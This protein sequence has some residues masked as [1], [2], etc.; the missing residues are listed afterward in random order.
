MKTGFVISLLAIAMLGAS[1]LAQE[2]TAND[3]L[4]KGYELMANGS[5]EEAAKAMQKSIDLSPSPT[6][7]TLWDAKAQS[8]A[9]AA[10]LIGNRSEYNESLKAEDKAIE[11]DPKN[12]TFLINKGFLIANLADVFGN[13]NASIYE[14]AVKEF[15]KVIQLDPRNKD[16]WNWKGMVLDSRLKRYDEAL[17]AYNKAIE[18]GGTDVG[19][20]FLLSNAWKGKGYDLAM[21][22]RYNESAAAFDKAIELNPQ[23]AV[24]IWYA[25]ATVL[26]ASGMYDEA[27]KAYDKAIELSK[28]DIT[29]TQAYEAQVYQDKG[30]AL[31]ELGKYD[32]AVSAYDK[33]IQL[34]PSEQ[35]TGSTWYKK[36]VA[37]KAQGKQS[38]ADAALAKAKELGYEK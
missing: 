16:A 12:S 2:D 11:L 14:D 15:D 29:I 36:G 7:A 4:K 20:N 18:I 21:L 34:F 6:N 28:G 30:S 17:A 24:Y 23:N 13:Q 19:D 32:E 1:S 22:G 3:W 31:F 5:Y 38:E 25:N 37:L 33:A 27:V 26:N 8:L 35:M 9:L 10:V